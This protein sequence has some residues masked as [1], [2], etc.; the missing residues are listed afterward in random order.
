MKRDDD[1][2]RLALGEIRFERG[3]AAAE[4]AERENDPETASLNRPASHQ[5]AEKL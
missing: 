5:P 1:L 3:L 4:R 2:V